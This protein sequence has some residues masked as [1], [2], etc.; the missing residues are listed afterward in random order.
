MKTNINFEKYLDP[1][2]EQDHIP[3][4]LE[5]PTKYDKKRHCLL[6]LEHFDLIDACQD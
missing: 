2:F 3:F 1:I 4:P 6:D 5:Y